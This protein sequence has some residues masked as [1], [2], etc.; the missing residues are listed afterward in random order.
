M[1]NE[2]SFHTR[3]GMAAFGN[4]T[5]VR[6]DSRAGACADP[7]PPT[8]PSCGGLQC[9]CRPRFFPGQ[10][11]TDDTLNQLSR[12]IVEKNRLH[13]RHLQGWGVACGLE[14]S[15]DPCKPQQVLVGTG[16]A[17]APCGDDIVVCNKQAVNIC[18]LIEACTP[19]RQPRCDPPYERPPQDCRG[20]NNRWVLAICYDERPSR[21]VTA[22]LG[23]GDSNC[24]APCQCGGASNCRSCGGSG[25]GGGAS[26]GCGG[27]GAASCNTNYNSQPRKTRQLNCE[28]TQV[29][30]GYRFVVYPAPKNTGIT[31]FPGADGNGSFLNRLMAWL[32]TN[33]ARFGPLIE[34][35][36]CCMSSAQDL[37]QDWGKSQQK[38]G[39]QALEAYVQY[40]QAM[41]NFTNEFTVHNCTF[42]A[43]AQRLYEGAIEFANTT[44]DVVE[45]TATQQAHI[46]SQL[47]QLDVTLM[48]IVS[49][50]LCSA[51]LPPC[52]APAQDNCVPL[53]VVTLRSNNCQ[54]V[55]ICN[56]QERK[57]LI[58]WPNMSYWLSW[59]PWHCLR[60]AIAKFCCGTGR[61]AAVQ[62][63]LGLVLG[64]SVLGAACGK[65]PGAQV[66]SPAA[67]D[68][69]GVGNVG[70]GQ[71]AHGQPVNHIIG[72]PATAAS[73]AVNAEKLVQDDNLVMQLLEKFD[74]TRSGQTSAPA[75]VKLVARASDGSLL[76]DIA[77]AGGAGGIAEM[78][79]QVSA[80]IRT[81]KAQQVQ[82]E[83][84][85]MRTSRPQGLVKATVKPAAKAVAKKANKPA[86]RQPK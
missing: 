35:L 33:R 25:C 16:Y 40:A 84:L 50:C 42:V 30:E 21:G 3:P 46:K 26:C 85:Q 20:G 23:A 18:E 28:P 71:P 79:T 68:G 64:V 58:T 29:C 12:Y 60:E 9:L 51:L 48:D 76:D 31:D 17:L 63:M 69:A 81:V 44:G 22:L 75:W 5:A 4:A 6:P 83:A 37:L 7:C 77:S 15:C 39:Q 74:R 47:D 54:V 55:D 70:I 59:L 73:N 41:V 61:N 78:Q 8:C 80:L 86:P 38:I 53:A 56:W 24:K 32:Y 43:K 65:R 62:Q 2:K 67:G 36:L 1:H 10:L 82:L 49:E 45:F 13:N 11:L 66:D 57:L 27:Q 34:R 72:Q 19:Q 14:V 52:P